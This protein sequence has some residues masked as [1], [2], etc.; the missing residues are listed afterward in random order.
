VPS[1]RDTAYPRLKAIPS[2]QDLKRL[3]TPSQAERAFADQYCGDPALLT[4]FLVLMK[5]FQRLGYFVAL[6]DV[7]PLIVTH[8][9]NKLGMPDSELDL[10]GYDLSGSR[11]R[12]MQ[13]IRDYLGVKRYDTLA[14]EWVADV[15]K[16]AAEHKEDLADI[17]NVAVEELVRQSYEL[18]GFTVLLRTARHTRAELNRVLYRQMDEMLTADDRR[19]IDQLFLVEPQTGRS[20]WARLKE[21]PGSPTLT[22][23]QELIGHVNWLRE[24]LLGARFGDF[25]PQA[26]LRQFASEAKSL[27]VTSMTRVPAPKRYAIAAALL[28]RQ[29]AR[30][31]D[32]LAEML[33][34]RVR[35]LHNDAKARLDLF[36]LEQQ[37]NTEKLVGVFR[38]MLVAY[39]TPGSVLE[40]FQAM[41]ET[42]G[43]QVDELI[44]QCD[45]LSAFA[46]DNYLP[47]MLPL[48][49]RQRQTLFA[50]LDQLELV[51]TTQDTTLQKAI[52]FVRQNQHRR[53]DQIPIV[54]WEQATR[55][56]LN[57]DWIPD[58]WWALVVPRV[59]RG[60]F[61]Y[62]VD[63]RYFELCVF[64]HLAIA[65]KAGDICIV[66]GEAYSD[67]RDQL[68]SWDDYKREIESYC[69]QVGL[70]S[71]PKEF[72]SRVKALLESVA[73]A[74]DRAFPTN[75]SAKIVN[76][77][78]VITKIRR[79]PDVA[80]EKSWQAETIARMPLFEILDVLTDTDKWVNWSRF[81]GPVS[82]NEPKRQDW[83]ER[84]LSTAFCYG[85]DLGPAQTERCLPGFDRKQLAFVNQRH[86]TEEK[87]DEA[88][89]EIVNAYNRFALPKLWGTGKSASADGTKWDL[90]EEN[91]LSEYHIRYGG[92]GG[93]GY[94]HV[95][96]MYIA[97]FSH[98]IPC[99]VWEAVYILDG[100]LKNKSEIQPDTLHADTQ[101]QNAP[102]FGLAHLLGIELMPR[103]RNWK[104]LTLFRPSKAASYEH[105]DTLF[106][107][108]IDWSMIE[109]MLPDMLRVTLSIKAGRIAA[110]TILR[111]LGTYSRG[112]RLYLAFRELGRVLRTVF[113]LR[114]LSN[115]RLRRI[116][117]A[118]TNKSEKFHDFLKWVFFG[119]E[120]IISENDREAQR[121][122]IKYNQLVAN[123]IVFHN[124]CTVTQILEQMEKEGKA[125]N[126]EALGKMS[127]YLTQHINRFGKYRINL[128]R[129]GPGPDYG[130]S[131]NDIGQLPAI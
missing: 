36:H 46:D 14:Q 45:G 100:L 3:F 93:I 80:V 64:A 17:V 77:K 33:V 72:V 130:F 113:L 110:S 24:H 84:S 63:R 92:Y 131:L 4:C 12:H 86:V 16:E 40:R 23:L 37:G 59:E 104:D 7:P 26:K 70:S 62:K 34:K 122:I 20:D 102:V 129:I 111:K 19:F 30:S 60:K 89:T 119:G 118:A 73:T 83:R 48:Y 39:Q 52:H 99:G 43:D 71:D 95:S 53:L 57:I 115:P 22:H 13:I 29:T 74:T 35:S 101:G 117:H 88:I 106:T 90:Y 112:N 1:I 58:K 96:D 8:V 2:R 75:E 47:F 69:E 9:A 51:S 32:D 116:I 11:R 41:S 105:I 44:A 103:I 28:Q 108:T 79:L 78:P 66:G 38:K 126:V 76:G 18:P 109:T 81:F 98:F 15:M 87:L 82:G 50:V 61:V 123:C 94:Y 125:I 6:R 114:Y 31:L 42:L 21:D 54:R 121:K 5:S 67:Y 120:K 10:K 85:C 127:P 55:V 68:V 25:V 56:E 128:N 124:V 27:D 91:L 65:L 97:L 107:D 49:Q